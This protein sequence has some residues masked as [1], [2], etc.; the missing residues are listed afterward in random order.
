MIVYKI[1]NKV[2]GKVYIG[3]TRG[4]LRNRWNSHCRNKKLSLITRAIEKYG[5][6]NFT[7]EEIDRAET[8]EELNTKES[9]WIKELDSSNKEIGYNI[10]P[11]GDSNTTHSE[12]TKV[13]ISR[14]AREISDETRKKMSDAKKGKKQS[15]ELIEAR[16]APRRGY[17]WTEESKRKSSEKQKGR[18]K[19]LESIAKMAAAHRGK[20]RTPEAIEKTA[21]ANRGRKATPEQKERYRQSALKREAKRREQN[22]KS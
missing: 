2:N 22:G 6:E 4:T 3:Q 14:K 9:R 12:E 5:R 8:R 13:I 18:P 1:T 7:I 17:T 19:S 21:A 20:K 11:G 15:P 16:I 10:M